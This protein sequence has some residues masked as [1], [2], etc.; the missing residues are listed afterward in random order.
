[1]GYQPKE[2]GSVAVSDALPQ[3]DLA[4]SPWMHFIVSVQICA[5]LIERNDSPLLFVGPFGSLCEFK[6]PEY[7]FIIEGFLP[8]RHFDPILK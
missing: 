3:I 8:S 1:M 6:F 4:E 5:H 7:L 2:I